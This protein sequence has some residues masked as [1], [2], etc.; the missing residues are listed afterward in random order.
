[1]RWSVDPPVEIISADTLG[2][3]ARADQGFAR[4]GF[5]RLLLGRCLS[6]NAR[7]EHASAFSLFLCCERESWHSTTIR[8]EECVIRTAESVL[9]TCWP[10]APEAR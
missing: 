6:L 9:L 2:T 7:R 3:V 5:L 8:W 1:M 10:P 4:G